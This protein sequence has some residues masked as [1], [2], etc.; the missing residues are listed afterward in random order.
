MN[1]IVSS[2]APAARSDSASLD[3]ILGAVKQ[4]HAL[5]GCRTCGLMSTFADLGRPSAAT[6]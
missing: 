1:T 3:Q 4:A 5:A 2:T 6:R